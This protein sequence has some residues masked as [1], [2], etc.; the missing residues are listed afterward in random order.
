MRFYRERVFPALAGA[1]WVWFLILDIGRLGDSTW[2]KFAGICLCCL[3]A[4]LGAKTTDGWLVAAAQCFTVAADRFLLVLDDHYAIGIGL[5]IVVQLIYAYR[6]CLHRD[7]LITEH[8]FVRLLALAGAIYIALKVDLVTALAVFY[9]ANLSANVHEGYM[10]SFG[11]CPDHPLPILGQP[12]RNRFGWGLFLFFWCDVCVGLYNLDILTPL[13]F[14]G[15]WFVYLPS[16]VLIVLSQEQE[17]GD[18][19]E[20]AF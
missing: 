6:L 9:F 5:F 10:G 2:V 1:L 20:K 7:K 3:T 15:M 8:V 19:D 11:I 14:P 17:K 16:Q 18:L 13:T 4:L 12:L